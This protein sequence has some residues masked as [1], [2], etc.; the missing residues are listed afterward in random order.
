MSEKPVI[1]ITEPEKQAIERNNLE[2]E[3]NNYDNSHLYYK[4]VDLGTFK[5]IANLRRENQLL[6]DQIK[7]Y[8]EEMQTLKIQ[9]SAREE[10]CKKLEV[11]VECLKLGVTL[12][13][14]QENLLDKVLFG[15]DSN[16]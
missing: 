7:N 12:N 1:L 3:I 8:I 6:E 11:L 9:I 13:Q 4:S 5:E 14:E 15:G 10:E 2:I 16:E